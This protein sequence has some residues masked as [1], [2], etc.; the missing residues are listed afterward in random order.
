MRCFQHSIQQQSF[1]DQSSSKNTG[2]VGP[3]GMSVTTYRCRRLPNLH[4]G[5]QRLQVVF[6]VIGQD[7]FVSVGM[8]IKHRPNGSAQSWFSRPNPLRRNSFNAA[9]DTRRPRFILTTTV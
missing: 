8:K 6:E 1:D 5:L 9:A 3:A 4:L 2:N 7:C